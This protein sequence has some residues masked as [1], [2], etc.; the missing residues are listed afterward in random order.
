MDNMKKMFI[1]IGLI[2]IGVGLFGTFITYQTSHADDEMT[3]HISSP[4]SIMTIEADNTP[5]TLVP[6]DANDITVVFS[7]MN[8]QDLTDGLHVATNDQSLTITVD[9]DNGLFFIPFLTQQPRLTVKVPRTQLETLSAQTANGRVIVKELAIDDIYLES[10]NGAMELINLHSRALRAN[11]SNGKVTLINTTGRIDAETK[12]GAIDAYSLTVTD[13]VTLRT[14]NGSINVSLSEDS[15]VR[16]E[17]NTSNGSVN[18]FG[19]D[20]RYE[21][22]NDGTYSLKLDTSNGSIDVY[23]D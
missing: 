21:V 2:L 13:D 22:L 10:S 12:N 5:I 3:E 20:N 11:T 6:A 18:I 9:Q 7:G 15:D 14:S 16:I 1:I 19:H 17:A 23:E 4:I 8:K